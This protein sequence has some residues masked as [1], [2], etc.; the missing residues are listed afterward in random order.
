MEPEVGLEPT[1]TRVTSDNPIL[2]PVENGSGKVERSASQ[3]SNLPPLRFNNG[4]LC[5]LN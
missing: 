3:D 2:R 1:T 5:Q 4:V